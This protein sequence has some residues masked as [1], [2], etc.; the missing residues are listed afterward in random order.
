MINVIDNI[1]PI[2]FNTSYE[3][4]IKRTKQRKN[5]G[6][7]YDKLPDSEKRKLLEKNG[8]LSKEITQ[9]YCKLRGIPYLE[10]DGDASI[11]DKYEQVVKHIDF[12]MKSIEDKN[13]L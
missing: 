8:H 5:P 3:N 13:T 4:H 2:H 1:Y 9:K 12:I 7:Y 11:E 6:Y 10:V